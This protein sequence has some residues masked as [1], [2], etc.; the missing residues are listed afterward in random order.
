M[1][2]LLILTTLL[3][4]PWGLNEVDKAKSRGLESNLIYP[5]TFVVQGILLMSLSALIP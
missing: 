5:M 4:W 3:R 2:D 1:P